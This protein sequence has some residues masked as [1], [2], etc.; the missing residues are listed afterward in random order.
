MIVVYMESSIKLKILSLDQRLTRPKQLLSLLVCCDLPSSMFFEAGRSHLRPAVHINL[1]E[2]FCRPVNI[3]KKKNEH[4]LQIIIYKYK[5]SNYLAK[6]F[7]AYHVSI[8]LISR[9]FISK[10]FCLGNV[11]G[12]TYFCETLM[13]FMKWNKKKTPQYHN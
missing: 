5:R 12:G 10:I 1:Y 13:S 11:F 9:F 3:S 4:V 7:L 8:S 6:L 2:F